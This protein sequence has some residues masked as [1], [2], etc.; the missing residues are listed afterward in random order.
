MKVNPFVEIISL[1]L[2]KQMRDSIYRI[3]L[4]KDKELQICNGSVVAQARTSESKYRG[5]LDGDPRIFKI[6][7]FSEVIY[8]NGNDRLAGGYHSIYGPAFLCF[9]ERNFADFSSKEI[10]EVSTD[11]GYLDPDRYFT[12]YRFDIRYIPTMHEVYEW[13]AKLEKIS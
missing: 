1:S 2:Q 13:M 11:P 10:I 9:A 3:Y 6:S 7:S 8:A 5:G 4:P 12:W